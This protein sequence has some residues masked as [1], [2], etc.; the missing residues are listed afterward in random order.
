MSIT[1]VYVRCI[2]HPGCWPVTTRMTW[3]MFRP[4]N[5]YQLN[6]YLALASWG[7][8]VDPMYMSWW[9][10]LW[11]FYLSFCHPSRDGR[12]NHVKSRSCDFAY[13]LLC[14]CKYVY[15][16]IFIP[17]YIE[18]PCFV[19][20]IVILDDMNKWDDPTSQFWVLELPAS[21]H[22][23]FSIFS[24]ARYNGPAASKHVGID[25]IG[26]GFEDSLFCSYGNAPIWLCV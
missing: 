11:C 4:G 9:S 26:G 21:V 19:I 15:I 14:G 25:Y 24:R 1:G 7:E 22:Y 23:V 8:K 2:S 3:S 12:W 20:W 17:N 13:P 10:F 18:I 16:C 6:L 5:P